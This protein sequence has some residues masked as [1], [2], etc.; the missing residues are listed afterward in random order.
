MQRE[1]EGDPRFQVKVTTESRYYEDQAGT[2]STFIGILGT[3]IT[4]IMSVGAIFGAMNT[5]YAAVGSRAR[6][7]ATLRAI[8]FGRTAVLAS[9]LVESLILAGIGGVLGCLLSLPLDGLTTGTI[10]WD[11]FSELAFAFQV[12]PGILTQGFMFALVMGTA[13]G[14]FPALRAA[15]IPIVSGLRQV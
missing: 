1:V 13:G 15:R 11:T 12:T 14:L 10:N 8:G 4:I 9:F 6:E 2:L 3:M 5:M 7:I